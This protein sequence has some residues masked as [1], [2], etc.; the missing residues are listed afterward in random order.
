MIYDEENES[1]S[2]F[3]GTYDALVSRMKRICGYA[4]DS[5]GASQGEVTHEAKADPFSDE[6]KDNVTDEKPHSKI[7]D[8][9]PV[10]TLEETKMA[11]QLVLTKQIA[12]EFCSSKSEFDLSKYTDI[13]DEAAAILGQYDGS[14][15]SG[16]NILLPGITRLGEAAAKSLFGF[17]GILELLNLETLSLTPSS[18]KDGTQLRADL[19]LGLTEL[20][21]ESAAALSST[22]GSLC[23]DQLQTLSDSAAACL[24]KHTGLLSL[25]SI[26]ALSDEAARLLNKRRDVYCSNFIDL[27]SPNAIALTFR[28]RGPHLYVDS[29]SAI[30]QLAEHADSLRET[31]TVDPTELGAD[32][33]LCESA[34]EALAKLPCR[35]RIC[36]CAID[37][38]LAS[39]LATF[40]ASALDLRE[41]NVFNEEAARNLLQFG[42]AILV[43]MN[44][45]DEAIRH[46]LKAHPSLAKWG[47]WKGPYVDIVCKNCGDQRQLEFPD[48]EATIYSV[49]G[50]G[51]G[52]WAL[53]P[54]C[55]EELSEEELTALED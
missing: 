16:P 7:E 47:E 45:H 51:P 1:W 12:E 29:V 3:E 28:G 55:R 26:H 9:E 50:D 48:N 30:E 18:L 44:A 27:S 11:D 53:C 40:K 37:E 25:D 31:W 6:S 34:I 19:T 4:M 8:H 41:C 42:G 24:A 17:E 33:C 21:D 36:G 49:F 52:P 23:L 32:E 43:K 35:I 20:S 39:R 13:T 2:F 15:Y 10:E 38:T 46:V 5:V 54:E 22:K 14:G